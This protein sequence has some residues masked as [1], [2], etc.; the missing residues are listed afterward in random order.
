M[1]TYG[2]RRM[3]PA[4][5]SRRRGSSES[6]SPAPD[7]SEFRLS[8]TS[9]GSSVDRSLDLLLFPEGLGDAHRTELGTAHRAEAR[10]LVGFVG[11]RL[12]VHRPG[13]F[14]IQRQSKLLFPVELEPRLRQ[15]V[16]T[17]AGPFPPAGD[18]RRMCGDLVGD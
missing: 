17:V 3:I 10:P 2:P 8:V 11:Q 9:R 14:R 7:L 6:A 4:A 13:S 16:V 1:R 15:G 18:V 12:V 5:T